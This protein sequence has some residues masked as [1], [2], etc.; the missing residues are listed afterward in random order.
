MLGFNGGLIGKT[1]IYTSVGANSGVWSLY[2]ALSSRR[3]VVATGGE[4]SDITVSGISYRVHKF[5]SSD[6]FVVSQGGDVDYLIVAGGGGGSWTNRVGGGGGAGG[7]LE[8][9][10]ILSSLSY[11]VV[12][13]NGGAGSPT[14][15]NNTAANNGDNSSF[16]AVVTIGGGRGG[17]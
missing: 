10:A 14:M 9:T 15:G 8:G 16:N 3:G 11:P 4:I 17:L 2:E 12:V 7:F 13:G 6:D 5:R 1:R